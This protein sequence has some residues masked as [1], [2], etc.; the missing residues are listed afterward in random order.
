MAAGARQGLASDPAPFPPC[1]SGAAQVLA[2][3]P[4]EE[5][6]SR[7]QPRPPPSH[8]GLERRPCWACATEDMGRG[9]PSRTS[10]RC[11]HLRT[12]R[13]SHPLITMSIAKLFLWAHSG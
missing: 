9:L 3:S 4:R 2:G 12:V 11:P 8:P 13:M 6:V 7:L 5:P 1:S 10:R